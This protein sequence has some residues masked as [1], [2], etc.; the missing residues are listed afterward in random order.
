[1]D[2]DRLDLLPR[3][4]SLEAVTANW[5]NANCHSVVLTRRYL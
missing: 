5:S 1:M 4:D 3:A 2:T